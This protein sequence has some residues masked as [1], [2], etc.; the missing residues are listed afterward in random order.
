MTVA[1]SRAYARRGAAQSALANHRLRSWRSSMTRDEAG[2]LPGQTMD[3]VAV[4][5]G[6]F[7]LG[8]YLG[9]AP[10]PTISLDRPLP[11]PAAG[12]LRALARDR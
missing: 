10:T 3:L 5:A 8:A 2:T 11:G 9:R 7:A 4:T 1:G 6:L 12:Q